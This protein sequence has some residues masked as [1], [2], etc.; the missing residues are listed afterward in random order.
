MSSIAAI[1]S[2][3]N[4]FRITGTPTTSSSSSN[5]T[6]QSPL[7]LSSPSPAD[8]SSTPTPSSLSPSPIPRSPATWVR[9]IHSMSSPIAPLS[10]Y[11]EAYESISH[12]PDYSNPHFAQLLL[13]Y[14]RLNV[15]FNKEK[16]FLA[17]KQHAPHLTSSLKSQFNEQISALESLLSLSVSES[18]TY[19]RVYEGIPPDTPFKTPDRRQFTN[20]LVTPSIVQSVSRLKLPVRRRFGPVKSGV[21]DRKLEQQQD[22]I[23]RNKIEV[24]TEE[25]KEEVV[26][27]SEKDGTQGQNDLIE[28]QNEVKKTHR[29]RFDVS[30]PSHSITR[31]SEST[32]ENP[33]KNLPPNIPDF[34]AQIKPK[35]PPREKKK[36]LVVN[37]VPY[38][39]LSL[40]GKGG[41]SRVFKALTPDNKVV[42]LKIVQFDSADE[43]TRNMLKN[44]VE[45]LRILQNSDLIINLVT[46]YEDNSSMILVLEYGETDLNKLL[47]RESNSDSC[48]NLS[49]NFI[50]LYFER[51]CKSVQI[52]HQN[53]IVHGDLKPA[54]FMLVSGQL[55]LI[56]F[57]IAGTISSDTTNIHRNTLT[58]T[59]NYLAPEAIVG[60]SESTSDDVIMKVG[61]KSDI[62]SLG[63][64]LYQMIYGRPPFDAYKN[65]YQKLRVIPDPYHQIEFPNKPGIPKSAEILLRRMLTR[66][67]DLRISL[68]E[69]LLHPFTNG[70][71]VTS[72]EHIVTCVNIKKFKSMLV[73]SLSL[74]TEVSDVILGELL[75]NVV[76]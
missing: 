33:N 43:G 62:W 29:V 15:P 68:D 35:E 51:M 30:T 60:H 5:E 50:R 3:L 14:V 2:K 27:E 16:S 28:G 46:Y 69:V 66:D 71:V 54:N 6:I 1:R 13:D 25:E 38:L 22:Q 61:R 73:D 44:E 18:S 9:L 24:D 63:C 74:S 21:P 64:I 36:T 57:G 11:S 40:I 70:N 19:T 20:H 10:L 58:G 72:D 55:K 53:R 37:E 34:S 52:I 59:L 45:F 47:Q 39:V 48:S 76:D 26:E 23:D 8:H 65:M 32:H 31:P 56:D 49:L 17:F 42:A 4:K 75:Q 67:V 41:S 12:N 7:P